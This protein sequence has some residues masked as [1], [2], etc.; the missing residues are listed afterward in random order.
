MKHLK[1]IKRFKNTFF[2][3]ELYLTL[4]HKRVKITG[5]IFW[6]NKK[7]DKNVRPCSNAIS[8]IVLNI[9]Y[10]FITLT[11]YPLPYEV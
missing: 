5:N 9:N 4:I 8:A 3:L 10:I 11:I 2:N 1:L 6:F 7:N